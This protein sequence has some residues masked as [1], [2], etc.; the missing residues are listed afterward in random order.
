MWSCF[1]G[2]YATSITAAQSAA[3][4]P[5]P[6]HN[7]GADGGYCDGYGWDLYGNPVGVGGT[8]YDSQYSPA[9]ST[10]FQSALDATAL[11]GM[12]RWGVMEIGAPWRNWDTGAVAR[13]QY[14]ADALTWLETRS[15]RPEHIVAFNAIGN[16]WDQRF[17]ADGLPTQFDHG[18]DVPRFVPVPATPDEPFQATFE[19]RIKGGVYSV[20]LGPS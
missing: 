11:N 6:T 9:Y 7:D 1:Q 19:A 4:L 14:M 15:P 16:K 3:W 8:R 2:P 20:Y 18:T 5:D 17:V 12:T 13:D 10:R